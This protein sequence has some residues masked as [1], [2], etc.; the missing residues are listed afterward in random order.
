MYLFLN[1]YICLTR[2][3]NF[4]P[5]FMKKQKLFAVT[6]IFLFLNCSLK[7]L[8]QTTS[9]YPAFQFNKS[10]SAGP[11]KASIDTRTTDPQN[12]K[13]VGTVDLEFPVTSVKSSLSISFVATWLKATNKWTFT[14]NKAVKTPL[15]NYGFQNI[16]LI[17][18][19]GNWQLKGDLDFKILKQLANSNSGSSVNANKINTNS[20]L[21]WSNGNL[22]IFL[23]QKLPSL[24]YADAS[25]EASQTISLSKTNEDWIPE[26]DTKLTLFSSVFQGKLTTLNKNL[27]YVLTPSS[28]NTTTIADIGSLNVETLNVTFN[29]GVQI[30]S[31]AVLK[32]ITTN[33]A[34]SV[35][36]NQFGVT[37]KGIPGELTINANH[38]PDIPELSLGNA[39]DLKIW[40]ISVKQTRT[41]KSGKST[42]VFNWKAG[43]QLDLAAHVM[44]GNMSFSDDKIK[45]KQVSLIDGFPKL[46]IE[47]KKTPSKGGNISW[48]LLLNQKIIP[49][50]INSFLKS[51]GLPN[52][53]GGN[54]I[55]MNGLISAEEMQITFDESLNFPTW[56]PS[57]FS[58]KVNSFTLTHDFVREESVI[59]LLVKDVDLSSIPGVTNDSKVDFSVVCGQGITNPTSKAESSK[60]WFLT[61]WEKL[62]V[63]TA[64]QFKW[65]NSN[66]SAINIGFAFG[67]A[68]TSKLI[69]TKNLNGATIS[70]IRGGGNEAGWSI[71]GEM[72]Y[73]L[74]LSSTNPI[75]KVVPSSVN[76]IFSYDGNTFEATNDINKSLDL[77]PQLNL[78]MKTLSLIHGSSKTWNL[79]S[80]SILDLFGKSIPGDIIIPSQGDPSFTP[81]LDPNGIEVDFG[82]A[83]NPFFK[84]L[85]L[86]L[87]ENFS[88]TGTAVLKKNIQNT[89]TASLESD[90][91][92]NFKV[93]KL[94][95]WSLSTDA[96]STSIVNIPIDNDVVSI[97][98]ITLS[99]VSK[100]APLVVSGNGH[101]SFNKGNKTQATFL[102][103]GDKTNLTVSNFEPITGVKMKAEIQISGADTNKMYTGSVS[104]NLSSAAVNAFYGAFKLTPGTTTSV[105]SVTGNF[106]NNDVKIAFANLPEVKNLADGPGLHFGTIDEITL[107]IKNGLTTIDIQSHMGISN[108]APLDNNGKSGLLVDVNIAKPNNG[109]A[110]GMDVSLVSK[111]PVSIGIGT[112]TF[113]SLDFGYHNSKW[114]ID[115]KATLNKFK[116][117]AQ[118]GFEILKLNPSFDLNIGYDT[119]SKNYVISS[120]IKGV[121]PPEIIPG[122]CQI[123]F[124][125]VKLTS[126][127]SG[128]D[129]SIV[130]SLIA[131]GIPFPG[132]IG[133]N[134]SVGS[135]DFKPS[136]NVSV[137][138]TKKFKNLGTLNVGNMVFSI[139]DFVSVSAETVKLTAENSKDIFWKALGTK[140][141]DG[142]FTA[143]NNGLSITMNIPLNASGKPELG[144]KIDMDV[145]GSA[146]FDISKITMSTQGDIVGSGSASIGNFIADITIGTTSSGQV[147][148]FTPKTAAPLTTKIQNKTKSWEAI[149]KSGKNFTMATNVLGIPT[150]KF[151]LISFKI[152]D[153][154]NPSNPYFDLKSKDFVFYLPGEAGTG[155]MFF[156]SLHGS[157][158]IA[159]LDCQ[160]NMSFPDPLS[161]SN[162][163]S[164]EQGIK[165]LLKGTT[166]FAT[167]LSLIKAPAFTISNSYVKLP[168]KL[169]GDKAQLHIPKKSYKIS[170]LGNMIKVPDLHK[171]GQT[172][173]ADAL[174]DIPGQNSVTIL[175]TTATSK[176][177][178]DPKVGFK[179][180]LTFNEPIG[181][182]VSIKESLTG[183][184]SKTTFKLQAKADVKFKTGS[185][186]NKMSGANILFTE[187]GF[188]IEGSLFGAKGTATIA[189]KSFSF[190]GRLNSKSLK[191]SIKGS[192]TSFHID[193]QWY[194]GGKPIGKKLS[195]GFS[196]PYV[197]VD[198]SGH[199]IS[200]KTKTK[201]KGSDYDFKYKGH[202]KFYILNPKVTCSVSVK[203]R[204]GYTQLSVQG[205][206]GIKKGDIVGKVKSGVACYKFSLNV[207]SKKTKVSKT[208][209]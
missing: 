186:W 138:F 133:F 118:K 13:I 190:K 63:T 29:N 208:G 161:K 131:N 64:N 42:S 154:K 98:Q 9:E 143:S 184:F 49:N 144:G 166:D 146:A 116:E 172:L 82:S 185:K 94:K 39:I 195:T 180:T 47:I 176:I 126:G 200:P 26:I 25:L 77:I 102:V 137:G 35:L 46:D 22:T 142:K 194:S 5:H 179:S 84:T 127:P 173:L 165:D 59:D 54:Q 31:S 90:V 169:F 14:Q 156:D 198:I 136:A 75:S 178:F 4:F 104:G 69:N 88:A 48:A 197:K 103:E 50:D 113:T 71:I 93:S 96:K 206:I 100:T 18:T 61:S 160:V 19:N 67:F 57:W 152:E 174:S 139:G 196:N 74:G 201:K 58:G 106:S 10:I 164:V 34:S 68:D 119:G 110:L 135:I 151:D 55:P 207:K 8:T 109:G 56:M 73:P 83:F 66:S 65:Y 209:C 97:N 121:K 189:D 175:G 6:L 163:A 188:T 53:S 95:G 27:E 134:P 204:I 130:S 45:L 150:I 122:L 70:N 123:D 16:T 128:T 2:L 15:D 183:N 107:E 158:N 60:A 168:S 87:G 105:S 1:S 203:G 79:K 23:K 80:K 111:V 91:D 162:T 117:F 32:P 129:F 76:M 120:K 36:P 148:K 72:K 81:I 153:P 132:E 89:I 62:G 171:I 140:E 125:K 147:F 33:I 20:S 112:L 155:F 44:T 202:L 86:S 141:L 52:L 205:K 41:R 11:L 78:E 115:G 149:F 37:I 21:T 159:G 177:T 17:E 85:N 114:S 170:A 193:A 40:P 181:K 92:L 51:L 192:Q 3:T 124:N 38:E 199:P 191:G 12:S 187:K 182:N 145:I 101:F 28:K 43:A 157:I 167:A 99:R 24:R 30:E 108:L 7:L